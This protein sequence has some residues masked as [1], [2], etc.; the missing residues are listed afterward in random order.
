MS[1]TP[2]AWG[3]AKASIAPK[4][5]SKTLCS[6]CCG[7]PKYN[8][9]NPSGP[10]N[11]DTTQAILCRFRLSAH[12]TPPHSSEHLQ[13][14]TGFSMA[15]GSN[16]AQLPWPLQTSTMDNIGFMQELNTARP[17]SGSL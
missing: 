5:T 3:P 12:S 1:A 17:V 2:S 10:N 15:S 7:N 13:K 4:V 11:K 6:A 9:S 16:G 14:N 8:S